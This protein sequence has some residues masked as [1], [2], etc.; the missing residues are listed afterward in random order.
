MKSFKCKKLWRYETCFLDRLRHGNLNETSKSFQVE[1]INRESANH[2]SRKTSQHTV[3]YWKRHLSN[4]WSSCNKQHEFE[5][6]FELQFIGDFTTTASELLA[7][8]TNLHWLLSSIKLAF[9]SDSRHL[10]TSW[11]WNRVVFAEIE[12]FHSL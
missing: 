4:W 6:R 12:T 9:M 3:L 7:T 2:H 1:K 5:N 8:K 11:A 10:E